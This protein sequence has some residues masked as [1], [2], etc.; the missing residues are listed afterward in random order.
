MSSSKR[1]RRGGGGRPERRIVVRG[2]RRDPPDLH[3]LSRALIAL[4]QAQAEKEAERQHTE[5]ADKPDG[6]EDAHGR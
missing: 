1:K 4:A 2:V 6:S 5:A 3:K